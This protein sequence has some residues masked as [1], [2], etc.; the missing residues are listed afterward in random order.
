MENTLLLRYSIGVESDSIVTKTKTL[1]PPNA[2]SPLG[3]SMS[4]RSTTLLY[5]SKRRGH[6]K[7]GLAYSH[8][9]VSFEEADPPVIMTG[10]SQSED[11]NQLT[12]VHLSSILHQQVLTYSK[13]KRL[14]I[15]VKSELSDFGI[16][17]WQTVRTGLPKA[18]DGIVVN[19]FKHNNEYVL[20]Y[21]TNDINVA[22][23]K[24]LNRWH[25]PT[26][27]PVTTRRH[28]F[29]RRNLRIVAAQVITQG[30]LVLYQTSR[31]RKRSQQLSIGAVLFDRKNPG[32]ELWRSSG[33]L[34]EVT[35]SKRDP[36]M[37]LGAVVYRQDILLYCSNASGGLFIINIP[38]PHS[39]EA[40]HV[41]PGLGLSR[42]AAN[43]II[44]PEGGGP[45]EAI[46]T[47]NPAVLHDNGK[48]HILYR[49]LDA[50]GIS[51]IGYAASHDGITIN[52]RS[53]TP[54]YWPREGFEAGTGI[55]PFK[56]WSE[57]FGSGGG[58]G[59][60]EDPKITRI[61]E[62]IYLT[63]VAHDGWSPPRLAMSTI[64]RQDFHDK[65]W[66]KWSKPRLISE[67]NVTNKSGI[68][69]PEKINGRYVVFHRV[70]PNVLIH[71]TDD[72]E[73]LGR[74][75]W[76]DSH[77][78]IA[79]RPHRWDSRKLSIGATPLRID[80]GWLVIYHAVDDRDD[81]KYKIGAM[82]LD[83]NDPSKI[84][85][86]SNNPILEPEM[87]YENE[88]KFGIAYPSGAA[89]IDDVLHVYYG[90]GDRHV[91]VATAPLHN[92]VEHLL[93]HKDT[94]L[95]DPRMVA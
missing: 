51:Q 82:I 12:T 52:E 29:D 62:K 72:L 56:R 7:L 67:P 85:A 15:A 6:N 2:V 92:F 59:G 46:G 30:I 49:A 65:N 39:L 33:P 50:A 4:G 94:Y 17:L 53:P 95:E 90:G 9:G 69:L 83:A 23:S 55:K 27:A 16:E 70:F 77:D 41:R 14:H 13:N 34:W 37:T 8:D 35:A 5:R 57:D 73:N 38:N 19:E 75:E 20:Y 10:R 32:R 28:S 47:F 93:R 42:H 1:L 22:L 80:E 88:W 24:D 40:S 74:S 60:C 58:W 84:I 61:G 91:C 31:T 54:A 18:E 63:Y 44:S 89:I 25:G 87:H 11:I 79:A 43:P 76:L 45:W 26:D 71:Y 81:N 3:V 48:V 36:V 78:I 66:D 86:R 64:S 21:S 68:I